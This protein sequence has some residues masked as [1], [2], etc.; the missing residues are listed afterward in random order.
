M[1][2]KRSVAVAMLVLVAAS[3][4]PGE[5]IVGW[6]TDGTGKYPDAKPLTSWSATENVIWKTPMPAWGNATPILVGDR[7]FVCAEPTTLV[8][9]DARTGAIQWQRENTTLD[10]LPPA[11]AAEAR[12]LLKEIDLVGLSKQ[13]RSAEGKLSRVN[14]R[15]RKAR[16]D[17][18]LKQQKADFET[19]V[20]TLKA[21]LKPVAH[22]V[23]PKCHGAN[24]YSSPTP[25]SDG[26]HVYA[27][28]GTGVAACYDLEGNRKWIRSLERPKDAYGHS[29]SPVLV[30]GKLIVHIISVFGLDA[31]TGKTLWTEKTSAAWGTST[32]AR[33]G[34]EDVLIMPN[35]DFRR[36]ADGRKLPV[37]RTVKLTYNQP[38]VDGGVVYFIQHGGKAFR[39]PASPDDKPQVL[40]QTTPKKDRYYAS[41]VIHQGLIY[42]VTQKGV[43]SAIDAGSGQV[44]WEQNLKLGRRQTFPSIVLAGK[45]LLVSNSDGKT[46]VIEPGREFR[47]VARNT[48]EPFR[49]TPVFRGTR[50]FVRAQKHL[51]CIGR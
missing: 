11:E 36:V 31:A 18:A 30:G 1:K 9:A 44:V 48:L 46:A 4:L 2:L 14:A 8:C 51:Y 19:Q 43:L 21:K 7:I 47:E 37:G 29:A 41:P 50:M 35:G 3:Q 20:S 39:L 34:A 5:E 25:V 24:G 45:V 38:I 42:A 26:R 16:D 17:A 28:F 33:I 49:A 22:L 23:L 32:P 40:W 12:R 6:R 27:V 13:L 10:A 15:L